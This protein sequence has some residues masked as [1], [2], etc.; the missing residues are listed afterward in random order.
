MLKN[1]IGT[2]LHLSSPLSSPDDLFHTMD[3]DAYDAFADIG[4]AVKEEP[5]TSSK[6]KKK[7][8][9][10]KRSAS[11]VSEGSTMSKGDGDGTQPNDVNA[12]HG[13]G[14]KKKKKKK[15]KTVDA[16]SAVDHSMDGQMSL[17]KKKHH[18]MH[19]PPL[20]GNYTKERSNLPVYQHRNELC[21][22]VAD[23][24]AV[25]V[26]AE[27]VSTYTIHPGDRKLHHLIIATIISFEI[28]KW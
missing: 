27:T 17:E 12:I 3:N 4:I 16:S 13:S 6:K 14:K 18:L 11:D 8:H 26:V 2:M 23:N 15:R 9:K 22:L 5:V 1:I 10:R 28:G 20:K 7:K 25:L 24:D 21:T 19:M